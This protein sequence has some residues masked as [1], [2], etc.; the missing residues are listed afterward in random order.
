MFAFVQRFCQAF[1]FRPYLKGLV[2][3]VACQL[4][5]IN[6]HDCP[7]TAALC[8]EIHSLKCWLGSHLT[9]ADAIPLSITSWICE[10]VNWEQE[11]CSRAGQ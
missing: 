7:V 8:V 9:M 1:Q 11:T 3:H 2:T 6:E 4:P 10:C 5:E